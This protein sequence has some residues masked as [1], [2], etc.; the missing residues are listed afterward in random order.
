MNATLINKS[1]ERAENLLM[2]ENVNKF[3]MTESFLSAN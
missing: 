3:Y 1:I 2:N